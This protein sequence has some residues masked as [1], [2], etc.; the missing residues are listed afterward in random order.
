MNKN[1]EMKKK[2]SD[3]AYALVHFGDK[4]KY[5]ELEIYFL[6]NLKK[7]TKQDILYLYS[8]HDTPKEFLKII[9]PLCTKVIGCDDKDLTYGFKYNSHYEHFN[10]LRV[11][12]Y[13]FGYL[14]TD[15][16]K[17]CYIESDMIVMKN[18]DNIFELRTP[19]ILSCTTK[20]NKKCFENDIVDLNR[21]KALKECRTDSFVQGG[22]MLF[23]PSREKF[24]EYIENLKIVIKN[25]CKFPTGTVWW[26]TNP[27]VY[28]LPIYYN[29]S[30]YRFWLLDKDPKLYDKVYIFHF[31]NID[32]KAI[33][34]LKE[35]NGILKNETKKYEK[36]TKVINWF[37]E[38]FYKKYHEYVEKIMEKITKNY[39]KKI[40]H[41]IKIKNL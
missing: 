15:Y 7:Y 35:S 37:Y 20:I 28:N 41:K 29:F 13:I 21:E 34:Y 38:H 24:N 23:E 22:L 4:P 11:C 31:N 33:D 19:A 27:I 1:R 14:C 26:L 10:I 18:L 40:S 9:K 36:Q 17:I 2:K 16:K 12:N 5:L 6:I 8:I 39:N 25:N 3:Y 30:H 32:K